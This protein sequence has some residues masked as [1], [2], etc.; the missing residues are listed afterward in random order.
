MDTT[1]EK[2]KEMINREYMIYFK[3][4]RKADIYPLDSP[5]EP[6]RI[7]TLNKSFNVNFK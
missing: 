1:D 5:F 4:E 3:R 2:I 6:I 7:N